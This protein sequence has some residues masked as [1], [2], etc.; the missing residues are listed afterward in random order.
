M[1]PGQK[2]ALAE[3][4]L[5][6]AEIAALAAVEDVDPRAARV[7]EDEE[8]AGRHLK[9]EDRFVDEHRLNRMTLRPHD[10]VLVMLVLLVCS[11]ICR[12]SSLRG[13]WRRRRRVLYLRIWRAILSMTAS[14]AA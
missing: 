14:I 3:R 7:H 4:R 5:D 12:M 2:A 9:L 13:R 6:Q 1:R 10:G 11:S 8:L